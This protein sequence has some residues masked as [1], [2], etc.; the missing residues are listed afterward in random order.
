MAIGWNAPGRTLITAPPETSQLD[1][2]TDLSTE[3]LAS[4]LEPRLPCAWMSSTS[5][6]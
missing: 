2:N 6:R 4:Y 5:G 1:V 3:F